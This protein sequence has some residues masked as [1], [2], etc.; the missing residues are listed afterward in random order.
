MG[1]FQNPPKM[2]KFILLF[3]GI[4]IASIW[5]ATRGD[6]A[7]LEAGYGRTVLRGKTDV[8]AM[9]VIWPNQIGRIDLF[10]GTLLVGSYSYDGK[11][12]D[13]Q[14]MLRGGFTANVGRHFGTT[15]GVVKLQHDDR[16]N[17]GPINFN[18]GLT[19][20]YKNLTASYL[21]VSNAGTHSPNTGR[22]MLILGWR[23]R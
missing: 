9:T 20:R 17:S 21:H 22:D 16:L 8:A 4:L 7:E 2:V 19:A 15:F 18:L 11:A 14:I 12:Y 5:F 6:A 23:F 13:N 3:V 1:L 10:A